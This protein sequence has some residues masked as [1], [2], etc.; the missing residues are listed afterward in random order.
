MGLVRKALFISTAGLSGLVL[1]DDEGKQGTTKAKAA[2]NRARAQKRAGS[3]KMKAKAPTAKAAPRS[4]AKRAPRPAAKGARRPAPIKA[5]A[6]AAPQAAGAPA[7]MQPM[8]S[9]NGTIG[10]LERLADLHARG[11]L[12]SIE[13]AAAKASMLG[14]GAVARAGADEAAAFPAIEANVAAA[15]QLADM[16]A[17]APGQS[18]GSAG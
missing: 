9:G 15:R 4:A 16:S 2:P 3:T 11:A 18:M 17:H 5:A 12:T 8:A 13:F 14:M 1:K 6:A 10:E 7:M